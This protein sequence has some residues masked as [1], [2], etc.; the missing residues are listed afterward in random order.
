MKG[1]II[2]V[3]Q[4]SRVLYLHEEEYHELLDD[5]KKLEE[6]L[7][8]MC[9]FDCESCWLS[10]IDIGWSRSE[11]FCKIHRYLDPRRNVIEGDKC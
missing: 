9:N 10:D 2:K 8:K 7:H 11:R 5:Y 3:K 4:F 1:K 6:V